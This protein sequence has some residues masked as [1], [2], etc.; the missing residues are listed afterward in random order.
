MA[1]FVDSSP[2]VAILADESDAKVWADSLQSVAVKSTSPIV[3][4]EVTLALCRV[5]RI[6]PEAAQNLVI[7]FLFRSGID[8][9][10]IPRTAYQ[11]ALSAH[12]QYGKGTGNP[13]QLNLGDCFSYAMAK[14]LGFRLL[15]KGNDFSYTDMA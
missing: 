3:I 13:A 5:F 4:Y 15:Y 7:E 14:L 11:I 8:I 12:A 9:V 6:P 10:D 2:I 1:V